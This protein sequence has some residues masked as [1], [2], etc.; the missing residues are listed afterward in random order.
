MGT[1]EANVPQD[2]QLSGSHILQEHCI[3]DNKDG[4]VTLIPHNGAL[5][6][7]NGKMLTEPEVLVT[8][9]RVILGK[10]HVFR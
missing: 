5:V 7:L 1:S 6:Y 4:V 2:I 8:G 10:N 3:F 9:S